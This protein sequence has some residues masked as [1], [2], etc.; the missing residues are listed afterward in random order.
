MAAVLPS[1][2]WNWV[3]LEPQ[4]TFIC[5][6]V[7]RESAKG[8]LRGGKGRTFAEFFGPQWG[9]VDDLEVPGH[10]HH[11]FLRYIQPISHR[12][13]PQPGFSSAYR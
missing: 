8:F 11:L 12:D 4:P 9:F 10:E 13:I 6:S 1:E 3:F 7:A 5:S 2:P